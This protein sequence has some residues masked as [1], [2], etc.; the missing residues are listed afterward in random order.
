MFQHKFK[1]EKEQIDIRHSNKI[2]D[3]F[4]QI[5]EI[6]IENDRLRNITPD[7]T[8]WLE[9]IDTLK[10]LI[11][12]EKAR[13]VQ[14]EEAYTQIFEENRASQEKIL[15]LQQREDESQ[16]LRNKHKAVEEQNLHL[17]AQT[18]LKVRLAVSKEKAW[19]EG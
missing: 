6:N 8:K 11:Q 10:S 17:I 5:Q 2:K 3:L 4:S 12:K 16:D 15:L 13:R 7:D 14:Q 18:E 19:N 9:Q 1:V